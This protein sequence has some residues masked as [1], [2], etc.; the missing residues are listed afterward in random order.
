MG[1]GLT[2]S[3]PHWSKG[4]QSPDLP[5]EEQTKAILADMFD[6]FN[7]CSPETLRINMFAF[8]RNHLRAILLHDLEPDS[9][10]DK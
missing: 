6:H 5:E 9:F 4:L 10:M 7:K 2:Q 8:I 1:N 3:G